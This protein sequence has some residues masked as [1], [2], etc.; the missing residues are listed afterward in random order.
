MLEILL[1]S[2]K[3]TLFVFTMMTIMDLINISTRGK[4]NLFISEHP[5]LQY[6]GAAF[7]GVTPGCIGAFA[8]VS[9]YTHGVISFGAITGCMIATSGDEAFIMLAKFPTKALVIFASLFLLGII[10]G[11]IVDKICVWLNFRPNRVCIC[12]VHDFIA[13]P[14]ITV[15]HFLHE[16]IVNDILKRHIWQLFIWSF[17]ALVFVKYFITQYNLREFLVN[18]KMLMVLGAS[19]LG[20]IPSSGPHL[21]FVYMYVD[22][23]IG[24]PVLLASSIV[25]DGHGMLPMF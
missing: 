2:L 23:L 13:E 10:V 14:K 9:L 4:F 25:Q 12:H 8:C 17:L 1:E 11:Y 19:I 7:L 20:L 24:L 16:H 15:R 3:I 5:L 21:V 22:G 6:I 18:H